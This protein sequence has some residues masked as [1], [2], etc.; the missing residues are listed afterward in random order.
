[1]NKICDPEPFDDTIDPFITQNRYIIP[2]T[3]QEHDDDSQ[4][5]EDQ[6][7]LE[8]RSTTSIASSDDH[9]DLN[10]AQMNILRDLTHHKTIALKHEGMANHFNTIA[11]SGSTFPNYT[12]PAINLRDQ[13]FFSSTCL[14]KLDDITKNFQKQ[15]CELLA[16]H[17]M[18]VAD[19]SKLLVTMRLRDISS[20][21]DDSELRNRLDN[22]SRNKSIEKYTSSFPKA[23][24]GRGRK[25][26]R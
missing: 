17:H 1:M 15:V 9:D 23:N 14:A 21:Y 16:A 5:M 26:P 25:R 6:N 7:L 12:K 3:N 22:L 10:T 19:R 8:T 11:S 24:R 13:K 2:A 4:H 20:I 18:E